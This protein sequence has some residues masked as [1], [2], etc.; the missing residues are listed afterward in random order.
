ME[1]KLKLT[2]K[3]KHFFSMQYSA[4][5]LSELCVLWMDFK[6]SAQFRIG[7]GTYTPMPS[8]DSHKR[9]FLI[10]T[11]QV[12]TNSITK[13]THVMFTAIQCP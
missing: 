7:V 9:N 12:F 6:L 10:T 3:F 2:C 1:V 8:T 11:K 5:I 13:S 4:S